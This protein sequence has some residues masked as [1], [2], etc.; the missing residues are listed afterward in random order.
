MR[1]T[2]RKMYNLLNKISKNSVSFFNE[3][4]KK[5]DGLVSEDTLEISFLIKELKN[6]NYIKGI[7]RF[8]S[9]HRPL[10][11]DSKK[12]YLTPESEIFM[13]EYKR[14]K[15]VFTILKKIINYIFVLIGVFYTILK[16]LEFFGI[17]GPY[18]NY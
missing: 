7:D 17:L 14:K 10:Y 12:I 5:F 16:I 2:E 15:S 18:C 8:S 9:K 13:K 4:D 1:I 3:F 11:L 6:R